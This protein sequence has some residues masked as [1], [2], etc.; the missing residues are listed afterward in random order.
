MTNEI[1]T[2]IQ[3]QS[4]GQLTLC[5]GL[6]CRVWEQGALLKGHLW[7][8]EGMN[9]AQRKTLSCDE[10]PGKAPGDLQWPDLEMGW[11]SKV[12]LSWRS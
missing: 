10:V 6:A 4:P 12:T 2:H 1:K 11:P 8:G 5:W 9:T 3:E 7:E